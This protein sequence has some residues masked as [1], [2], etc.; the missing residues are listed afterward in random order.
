ML[1]LA[2]SGLGAV[3]PIGDTQL[4][5]H[6]FSHFCH[7]GLGHLRFPVSLQLDVLFLDP[8]TDSSHPLQGQLG[9]WTLLFGY[10]RQDFLGAGLAGAEALRLRPL[11]NLGWCLEM[12]LLRAVGPLTLV[13]VAASIAAAALVSITA[14]A[15]TTV[16]AVTSAASAACFTIPAAALA[17][18]ALGLCFDD[19][20][21]GLVIWQQLH[22]AATLVLV[23]RLD[24][25]QDFHP[26][27]HLFGFN[28]YDV[29]DRCTIV[30]N[31]TVH[32]AFRL[33]GSGCTPCPR[34][35]RARA[36]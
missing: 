35:V 9:N 23:T 28:F 24:D 2:L 13:A 36:C 10:R 26:I 18:A 6:L 30:E 21:E 34:T 7:A 32:D 19:G 15:T 4:W 25:R 20:L 27:E 8:G 11:R 12:W 33:E 5:Q 17:A 29:T 14:G 31:R 3:E 22:E 16:V 1:H